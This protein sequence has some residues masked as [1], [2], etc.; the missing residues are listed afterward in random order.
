MKNCL[1]RSI[2]RLF[3]ISAVLGLIG[4]G[5][6]PGTLELNYPA[7]EMID[8]HGETAEF[9]NG[10]RIF[11]TPVFAETARVGG[12]MVVRT[13]SQI[14]RFTIPRMSFDRRGSFVI[15]SSESASQDLSGGFR[16]DKLQDAEGEQIVSCKLQGD[17]TEGK[18]VLVGEFVALVKDPNLCKGTQMARVR[19]VIWQTAYE[20]QFGTLGRFRSDPQ[21]TT[22]VKVLKPLS[23]CR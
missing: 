7:I 18:Q 21:T 17:C 22:D 15:P 11:V 8:N 3:F 12:E 19:K 13:S 20:V 4:C 6:I 5:E 14:L 9:H 23:K 16:E 10:E 1:H 2:L